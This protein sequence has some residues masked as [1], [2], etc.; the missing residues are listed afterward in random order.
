MSYDEVMDIIYCAAEDCPRFE[1][2]H[3][4]K[5]LEGKHIIVSMYD[6]SNVCGAYKRQFEPYM[7]M[8]N[9]E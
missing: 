6:F 9:G 4:R 3:N 1:C 5:H 2:M 7:P 8:E